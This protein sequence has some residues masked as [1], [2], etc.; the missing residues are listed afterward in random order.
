MFDNVEIISE[1]LCLFQFRKG[2]GTDFNLRL[3]GA[4]VLELGKLALYECYYD[5]IV[6]TFPMCKLLLSNTDSLLVSVPNPDNNYIERLK[7]LGD[8][9]DF[10]NL[11]NNHPLFSEVNKELPGYWKIVHTDIVEFVGLR[12]TNYSLKF[13]YKDIHYRCKGLKKGTIY[14]ADRHEEIRS[15]VYD[16]ESKRIPIQDI[17]I[18]LDGVLH[19]NVHK[20]D[21]GSVDISRIWYDPCYSVPFGF[22]GPLFFNDLVKYSM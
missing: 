19:I 16:Y 22:A 6:P 12:V 21:A 1:K 13:G 3:I 20:L 7:G 9:F 11:P 15:A 4:V 18:G 2:E 5:K 17:S 14:N 10:S 8:T